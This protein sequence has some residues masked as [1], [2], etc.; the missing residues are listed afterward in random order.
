MFM[1]STCAFV[2]RAIPE[3]IKMSVNDLREKYFII[4]LNLD[5]F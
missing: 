2:V 3:T 1:L 4:I 5:R